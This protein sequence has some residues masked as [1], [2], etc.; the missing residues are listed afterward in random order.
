M[1]SVCSYH[2][3]MLGPAGI[4]VITSAIWALWFLP[5]S[6]GLCSDNMLVELYHL[7]MQMLSNCTKFV[8]IHLDRY[9]M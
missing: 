9:S 8:V 4:V 6:S 7:S 3:A 2:A 1:C 5:T